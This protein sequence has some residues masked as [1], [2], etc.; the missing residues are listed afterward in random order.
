M[1]RVRSAL[2]QLPSVYAVGFDLD[3]D[4]VYVGYDA[5]VGPPAQ[6]ARPMVAAIEGAGYRSWYARPGRAEGSEL[7]PAPAVR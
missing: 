3:R 2:A 6:A 7:T 1:H 4:E 5:T